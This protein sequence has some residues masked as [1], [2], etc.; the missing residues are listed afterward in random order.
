MQSAASGEKDTG[1]TFREQRAGSG[2]VIE[3]LKKRKHKKGK[4]FEQRRK[5][6]ELTES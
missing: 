1:Y 5:S 4:N 3:T 2:E 6:R